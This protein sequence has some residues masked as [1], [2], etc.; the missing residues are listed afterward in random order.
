MCRQRAGCNAGTLRGLVEACRQRAGWNADG[1][2]GAKKAHKADGQAGWK[3]PRRQAR[4]PN[5]RGLCAG[6]G[7]F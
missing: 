4:M 1:K 2:P 3:L 7:A 6:K 5:K